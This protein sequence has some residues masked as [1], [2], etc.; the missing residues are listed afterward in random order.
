[1]AKWELEFP[2]DADGKTDDHDVD[3]EIGDGDSSKEHARVNALMCDALFP[4]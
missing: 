3:E 1:M 2:D 4:G